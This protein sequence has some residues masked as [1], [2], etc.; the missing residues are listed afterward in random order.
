M[1]E[2]GP[3][4]GDRPG[5]S[6]ISGSNRTDRLAHYRRNSGLATALRQSYAFRATDALQ[7]GHSRGLPGG[8]QA[9]GYVMN[10]MS[11]F[12]PVDVRRC[13]SWPA[14]MLVLTISPMC[15]LAAWGQDS[16]ASPLFAQTTLSFT[17][18]N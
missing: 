12:K 7:P 6:T 15:F 3:Q 10:C 13:P 4:R 11:L 16:W 14:R 18:G 8:R 2:A 5:G 9:E 17:T 1:P